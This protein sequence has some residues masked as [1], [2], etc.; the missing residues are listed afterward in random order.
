LQLIVVTSAVLKQGSVVSA[1]Q[2]IIICVK[3]VMKKNQNQLPV[4]ADVCASALQG[5]VS[6]SQLTNVCARYKATNWQQL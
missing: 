2:C 5:M 6:R 1:S 4:S 3:H